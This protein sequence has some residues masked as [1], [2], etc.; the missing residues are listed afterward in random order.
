MKNLLDRY[1]PYP[2]NKLP[3]LPVPIPLDTLFLVNLLTR[4][5]AAF[6]ARR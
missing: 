6:F 2:L 5:L 1:T 3:Y 4:Q